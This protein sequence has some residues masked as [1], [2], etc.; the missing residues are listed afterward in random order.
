MIN[1]YTSGADITAGVAAGKYLQVYD[2][3]GSGKV[4]RFYEKQLASGDVKTVAADLTVTVGQGSVAGSTKANI[5][6]AATSKFVVNITTASAGTTYVGDT[7]PTSG[8]NLV[9]AYPSGSDITAGV[10]EDKYLQVYD[11]DG[12]GKVVR[13]YEKLLVAGDIKTKIGR[14]HV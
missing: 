9:N 14:A 11:V 2:V 5:A 12:S 8:V 7:A 1:G 3:D 13:F 6:G 4:V 10:A